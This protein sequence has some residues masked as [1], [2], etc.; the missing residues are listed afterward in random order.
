MNTFVTT[1]LIYD[2][3]SQFDTL[4]LSDFLD[5]IQLQAYLT[6]HEIDD[7]GIHRVGVSLG[8]WMRNFPNAVVKDGASNHKKRKKQQLN[9]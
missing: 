9:G 5:S 7:I 4:V 6:A 8:Q 2:S 3:L 1:P